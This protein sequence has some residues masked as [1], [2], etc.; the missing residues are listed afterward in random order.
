MFAD[1]KRQV[2]LIV[3]AGMGVLVLIAAAVLLLD[4]RSLVQTN[5][6]QV[7]AAISDV[8]YD[9]LPQMRPRFDDE[10]NFIEYEED[11]QLPRGVDMRGKLQRGQTFSGQVGLYRMEGWVLDA[12]QGEQYLLDF[13]QLEGGY[14]WQMTVYKPDRNMLAFTAESDAGYADFTQLLVDIPADGLYVVVLSGF[15]ESDGEYALAVY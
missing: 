5:A 3:G 13:E 9:T 8:V 15:G 11:Y 6:P 1:E 4:V 7:K 12:K 10:G 2:L 14:I